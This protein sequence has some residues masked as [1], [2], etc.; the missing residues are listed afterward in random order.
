M[1]R[2]LLLSL[3]ITSISTFADDCEQTELRLNPQIEHNE[4]ESQRSYPFL[5]TRANRIEMNGADW[6]RLRQAFAAARDSGELF[7]VVYLGD[8][9]IQADFS[10]AVLRARLA[11]ETAS[12]GRGLIVPFRLAGTNQPADYTIKLHSDFLSAKLM[13]MPWAVEMPFTGIGIQPSPGKAGFEISADEPFAMLRLHFRGERPEI[14]GAR[15]LE[16]GKSLEYAFADSTIVLSRPT[17]RVLIEFDTA[18]ATVFGGFE[19]LNGLG[20]TLVHS[21]G[22]NG[23]TY[24][25]YANIDRFGPQISS[26]APDLV[27]IALGTNEAFGSISDETLGNDIDNLVGNIRRHNPDAE[28]ML[29]A[30]AECYRRVYRRRKGRRRRTSV[31]TVNTKIARVRNVISRYAGENGIPF[32]DTYAVA[33]GPGSAAKMKAAR[34]LGSDGVH[35]TAAGYRMWGSLLSDAIISALETPQN[36]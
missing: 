3:L 9:H 19:L 21:V 35:Y 36:P 1:N 23:A 8:S 30:P 33:G 6:S 10:G 24:S 12:A 32:Y 28:I 20:G 29:V 5:D 7:S 11:G 15:D 2:F 31:L 17:H 27:V 25:S 16:L 14:T 22:N 26:L 34:V 18:D 13:K 4:A